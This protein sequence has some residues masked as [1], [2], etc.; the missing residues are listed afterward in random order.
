ME[1][2]T[3]KAGLLP[4]AVKKEVGQFNVFPMEAYVGDNPQPLPYSRK[5]YYKISLVLGRNRY[6]YA[7]KSLE[8]KENGLF[9]GN[10]MVPYSCEPLDYAL[11][12]GYF[13]IFT[14]AFF[15]GFGELQQ[16]PLF[17][18]E[19][20]PIYDLTPS[21]TAEITEVFKR[22]LKEINSG[23]AYKYDVLR[24]IA[25][26]LMHRAMKMRPIVPERHSG[27]TA[28]HRVSSFFT[29]LLERQFPITEPG[30]QVLLKKPA[31]FARQ[32][33]VHVNHLNQALK[34]ETGKTTS[35]CIA[36]RVLQEA[37]ALLKHT[38]WTI[39]QIAWCLGFEEPAHFISFFRKNTQQ[40]PGAFRL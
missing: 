25:L 18:P 12:S 9:F 33:N 26:E 15:K 29:E 8:I 34:A 37:R 31:D 6:H 11:Q 27:S 2:L 35:A 5:D 23:Y 32:L 30:Q 22:M 39:Q 36:A 17:Q 20:D 13:C 14:P 3:G 19:A 21:E 40:T 7:D 24:A 16:Y 38:D 1:A 10:P 28:N 4:D